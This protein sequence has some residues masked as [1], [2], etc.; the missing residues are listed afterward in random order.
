[1][2]CAMC[3]CNICDKW[4]CWWVEVSVIMVNFVY[5]HFSSCEYIHNVGLLLNGTQFTSSKTAYT[6]PSCPDLAQTW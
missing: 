4:M 3:R 5:I 1:M 6:V 2:Q